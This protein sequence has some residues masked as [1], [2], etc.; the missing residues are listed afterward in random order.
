MDKSLV[1]FLANSI[2]EA[3]DTDRSG[4]ISFEEFLKAMSRYPDL[5]MG[6]TI[7]GPGM[8]RGDGCSAEK[9]FYAWIK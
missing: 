7:K 5:A 2:M 3:F 4:D 9:G 8:I 1:G 6:L